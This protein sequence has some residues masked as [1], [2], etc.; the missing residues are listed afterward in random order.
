MGRSPSTMEIPLAFLEE[1]KRRGGRE[2][3]LVRWLLC[4]ELYAN[5]PQASLPRGPPG[6]HLTREKLRLRKVKVT[7]PRSLS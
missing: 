2:L 7:C 5:V 1:E 6:L 4:G 3:T